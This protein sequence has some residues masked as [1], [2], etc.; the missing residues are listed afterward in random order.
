MPQIL[1]CRPLLR[2]S[3]AARGPRHCV[4]VRRAFTGVA[5]TH[6]SVRFGISG[7]TADGAGRRRRCALN[8]TRP[9]TSPNRRP[10]ASARGPEDAVT[11]RRFPERP[12]HPPSLTRRRQAPRRSP[13]R[14]LSTRTRTNGGAP[15]TLS[16]T[17]RLAL[18]PRTGMVTLTPTSEG[19]V[20]GCDLT[21]LDAREG[22]EGDDRTERVQRDVCAPR[23]HLEIGHDTLG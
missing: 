19:R 16:C 11:T 1:G 5:L 10:T 6:S 23:T 12:Q 14:P 2:R 8:H 20:F 4:V 18:A 7:T 15:S 3:F 13:L 21:E 22:D 9:T 17:A